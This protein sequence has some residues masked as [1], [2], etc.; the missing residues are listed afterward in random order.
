MENLGWIHC[1]LNAPGFIKQHEIFWDALSPHDLHVLDDHSWIALYLSVLC[2]SPFAAIVT[3]VLKELQIGIYFMEA[4]QISQLHFLHEG[5]SGR[6]KT[7][8]QDARNTQKVSWLYYETALQ[9]L[10]HADFLGAPSLSTVQTLAL[11]SLVHRNFGQVEREHILL[12][13]A[14]STAKAL[15]MDCLGRESSMI[16]QVMTSPCWAD[17]KSRE[18]GRRLWWTL[19]ICDW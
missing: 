16:D 10:D 6:A 7:L 9:E 17:R 13:V 3:P 8:S 18:M 11:L 5:F 4:D 12:S 1:A 14:I 2:V 15:S 19:V